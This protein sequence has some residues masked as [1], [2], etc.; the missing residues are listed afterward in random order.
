MQYLAIWQQRNFKA[1]YSIQQHVNFLRRR[2][3]RSVHSLPCVDCSFR[4]TSSVY[5]Y[6]RK[7]PALWV[8]VTSTRSLR[9]GHA[10]VARNAINKNQADLTEFLKYN[11]EKF[12]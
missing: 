9:K 7:Y 5:K 8:S 12:T 2:I 11:S 1:I 6:V 4:L 10:A 3:I